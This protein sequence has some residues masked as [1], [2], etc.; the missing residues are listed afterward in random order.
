MEQSPEEQKVRD[1]WFLRQ[2]YRQALYSLDPGTQVGAILIVDLHPGHTTSA[3]GYNHF[4]KDLEKVT[5]INC[6]DM[7]YDRNLKLRYVIHAEVAAI[8]D[9]ARNGI[10][11]KGATLYC[12]WG[13]CLGCAKIILDA[14]VSRL[15]THH[16]KRMDQ[17]LAW[18]REVEEA[19]SYLSSQGVEV[20]VINEDLN[21]NLWVRFNRQEIKV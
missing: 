10:P 5:K 16:H 17:H 2:A 18:Q 7:W 19:R 13:C 9:A 1:K 15:V 6:Y 4:S 14:G 11:T 20:C 8:I 12:T 3:H 21:A